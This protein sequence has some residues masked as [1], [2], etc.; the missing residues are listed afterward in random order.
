[1]SGVLSGIRVLELGGKGPTPFAGMM[2]ADMGADVV[3]VDRAGAVP[4]DD[5][6]VFGRGKHRLRLD[7]KSPEAR[8]LLHAA[9]SLIDVVIEGFRPGVAERLGLGPADVHAVNPRVV[10]GRMTGYGQ[11]GPWSRVPGH[12]VNFIAMSSAL[13]HIG[14]R[15]GPPVVPLNLVG[16]FGGGGMLLV[17]GVLGA[18]VERGTSGRGQV[19]DAAMTDGS[20][21]LMAWAYAARAHGDWSDER[22]ANA[23]DGSAPFYRAYETADGGFVSVGALDPGH[24]AE[25]MRVCGIDPAPDQYD[26]TQWPALSRRL[27]ETFA[28][29]DR[30]SWVARFDG[31]ETSFAPV[32]TMAEAHTHPYNVERETFVE[33]DG[34]LQPAPA[35]RFDRTPSRPRPPAPA[36]A[37]SALAVLGVGERDARDLLARGVAG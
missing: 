3:A 30:A 35:P 5:L 31:V 10:Y 17:T 19:V 14:P 13:A 24:Y 27:E 8:G 22:G 33:L 7:L 1:V 29:R 12:D 20:A 2:L 18:L 16:D 28:A 36:D 4:P 21:Q 6:S 15:E 34:V 23:T 11:D 25:L 32:L 37:V 26:R 9:M